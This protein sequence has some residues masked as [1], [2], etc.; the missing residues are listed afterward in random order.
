M[1]GNTLCKVLLVVWCVLFLRCE[2][3]E[4]SMVRAVFLE[5][6]DQQWTV[7]LLYQW[8]EA[9][10]DASEAEAELQFTAASAGTL[11]AAFS[12]AEKTLPQTANYRLCDFLLFP[13][14]LPWNAL[15]E[16]ETL[17][18]QRACGRTAA[19]LSCTEFTAEE[20]LETCETEELLPDKLAEKLKEQKSIM[21]HLYEQTEGVLL[22]VLAPEEKGGL[23]C[24]ETAVFQPAEG[25]AFALDADQTEAVRLLTSA[26]GTRSLWLDGR[27]VKIRRCVVSTTLQSDRVMLRLDCQNAYGMPVPDAAQCA[28]LEALCT[29][30]IT[31]FWAQG[32]DL[33]H[34]E[35]R[36]AL[37]LRNR[38][39]TPTKNACPQVQADVQFL[40]QMAG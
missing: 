39:F 13:Q 15:T 40:E 25:A 24:L 7:G 32:I 36:S 14:T 28:A 21:P 17:L 31:E 10:A 18:L 22:P 16:Y 4:K 6:D 9:S 5:Q 37:Q 3:T 23:I 8:P 2:T 38:S 29:R 27:Q 30:T 26:P 35:Q 11:E 1:K 19:R 12:A 33:L 20:F 34:L